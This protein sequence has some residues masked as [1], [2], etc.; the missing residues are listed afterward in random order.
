MNTRWDTLIGVY[1]ILSE[2]HVVTS[3]HIHHKEGHKH[4]FAPNHYLFADYSF[5]LRRI[6]CAKAKI[7][8]FKITFNVAELLE[9]QQWQDV[10]ACTSI[11][12]HV[13]DRRSVQVPPDEKMLHV[14]TRIFRILG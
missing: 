1:P 2:Q 4:N 5:C 11:N 3:L 6:T 12:K 10:D 8:T 13:S 14:R 7:C 9:Q